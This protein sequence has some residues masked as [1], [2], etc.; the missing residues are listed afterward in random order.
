MVD[1][2][3]NSDLGNKVSVGSDTRLSSLELSNAMPFIDFHFNNSSK[4]YTSRLIEGGEGI[5]QF[6]CSDLQFNYKTVATIQSLNDLVY[7]VTTTVPNTSDETLVAT[8][9]RTIDNYFFLGYTFDQGV[10]KQISYND[11]GFRFLSDK[12]YCTFKGNSYWFGKELRL[13]FIKINQ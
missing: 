12:I 10:G 11:Y 13:A 4:D 6:I 2:E 5:L 3:I 1:I 7:I 9:P 8:L